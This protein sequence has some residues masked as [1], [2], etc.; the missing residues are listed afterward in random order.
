MKKITRDSNPKLFRLMNDVD[1]ALRNL[2]M[3]I[4]ENI[5]GIKGTGD[6][7]IRVYDGNADV[8]INKKWN[9]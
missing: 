3:E 8:S 5:F 7:V 2:N 6:V 9:V 4:Y 1:Y